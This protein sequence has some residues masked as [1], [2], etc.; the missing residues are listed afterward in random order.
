MTPEIVWHH[1]TNKTAL[2]R[3]LKGRTACVVPARYELLVPTTH[4]AAC[5]MLEASG[6]VDVLVDGD[7]VRIERRAL[8]ADVEAHFKRVV[9]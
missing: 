3:I 9:A 6:A 7:W 4:D 5:E 8:A 2:R 1:V